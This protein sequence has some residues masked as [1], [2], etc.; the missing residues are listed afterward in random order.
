MLAQIGYQSDWFDVLQNDFVI[1]AIV[2]GS[3]V[4][5]A[6]SI[7]G[8][9]VVIRRDS[10]AAHALAHIGFPGATGAV[11][12]GAPVTLGLIVFCVGGALAIG[13]LGSKAAQR[14]TTTGTVLA[15]ATALGVLFASMTTRSSN[16]VTSVLFGSLLTISTSQ[17]VQFVLIST[18]AIGVIALISRPLLFSSINPQVAQARGVA[19]GALN[20]VFML[21]LAIVIAVAIQVVG[22]LLLFALIV[23][24]A[25]AALMLTARPTQAVGIAALIAVSSVVLGVVL[26]TMFNLPP[27]FAIVTIAVGVWLAVTLATKL[28]QRRQHRSDLGDVHATVA[29]PVGAEVKQHVGEPGV[30]TQEEARSIDSALLGIGAVSNALSSAVKRS[31]LIDTLDGK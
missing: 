5:I 8:Y 28:A 18:L 1:R 2:G 31:K 19:V 22:T 26:A 17:L 29:Q 4:A 9:F 3:V 12:I 16:N 11:L 23:T 14:E 20:I 6:A 7:V 13:A 24:P 10:F 15:F 30:A 27:S 25:S 21:T